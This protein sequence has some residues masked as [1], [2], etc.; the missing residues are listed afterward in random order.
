MAD[1][2]NKHWLGTFLQNPTYDKTFS[3]F[4]LQ[5]SVSFNFLFFFSRHKS[6]LTLW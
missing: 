1:G 4:V 5:L 3:V 6:V 2:Q